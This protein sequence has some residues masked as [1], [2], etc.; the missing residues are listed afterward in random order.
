MRALV[1]LR[2]QLGL[3]EAL[4]LGVGGTI[5]GGIFVL[6]GTAAGVAGPA[7]LLSFVLAFVASLSIAL[8]YAELS[9]RYPHAGGGYAF[10][11]SV[12]GRKWG[13]FMGWGYWGAYLFISGYVTLGFGGYL[14]A[15][16]GTPVAFGAVGIVAFCMVL[17]LMGMKVSGRTQTVVILLAVSSLILFSLIGLPRVNESNLSPF[18]PTG[19][20][21]IL[22]GALLCFLAFGGFDIVA[23]AGEEIKNPRRT[24]PHAM[25]LTLCSVLGL[26][27]L[28]AYVAVGMVPWHQLAASNAPLS[29]AASNSISPSFGPTLVS[30]AAI[31]TTA[32]TANAVLVVTSRIV[33]AMSREGVFPK[34]L[35]T[36]SRSKGA[37]WISVVVCGLLMGLVGAF[38][39]VNL[40]TAIGGFL[41]VVH[42]MFP[43]AAV[44][45]LRRAEQRTLER[46]IGETD[47]F[48]MPLPFIFLPAAVV[49]G[50]ILILASGE[51]GVLFGTSWLALGAAI[52]VIRGRTLSGLVLRA[53][54]GCDVRFETG[55]FE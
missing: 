21:G 23:A 35:S 2:R 41:Y 7:V 36:V 31:L 6:I 16:T 10:V 54:E 15:L 44:I 4:A 13:F 29:L 14:R 40:V 42:F 26:Y 20:S 24:L 53:S 18:L 43:L 49:F 46:T 34:A 52:L 3:V 32:A 22:L 51:V 17:N 1:E 11:H 27:L 50:T 19:L 12:F 28:V 30:L 45:K 38:G 9:C 37:P 48:R 25:I 8:P 47:L 5:G 33:F 39:T 55:D